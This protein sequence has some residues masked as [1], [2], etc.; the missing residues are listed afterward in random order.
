M[1]RVD[2][3]FVRADSNNFFNKPIPRYSPELPGSAGFGKTLGLSNE[4]PATQKVIDF[5]RRLRQALTS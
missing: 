2:Q 5:I 3:I 4:I 1:R